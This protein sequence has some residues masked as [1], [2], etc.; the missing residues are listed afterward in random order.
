[1][2][3]RKRGNFKG[4][5]KDID[6]F[7]VAAPTASDTFDK[8]RTRH[9]TYEQ[10]PYIVKPKRDKRRRTEEEEDSSVP[11][12]PY[13][14]T[15]TEAIDTE[16]GQEITQ[17]IKEKAYQRQRALISQRGKTGGPIYDIPRPLSIPVP[18]PE[19]K[20]GQSSQRTTSVQA[21]VSTPQYGEL[22]IKNRSLTQTPKYFDQ[23][24]ETMD[25]VKKLSLPTG[26]S[27]FVNYRQAVLDALD[28]QTPRTRSRAR[29][30]LSEI[31][32]PPMVHGIMPEESSSDQGRT[33]SQPKF[34]VYVPMTQS[35]VEGTDEN[36][37]SQIPMCT[38]VE[39][40]TQF[41]QT[42]QGDSVI[43]VPTMTLVSDK[44]RTSTL[45]KPIEPDFYLPGGVRLSEVKTYR[46]EELS[47]DG[48]PAVMVKLS[49]LKTVYNTDM[50]ML[51]KY[52]GHLF[53]TDE[54]GVYMKTQ[55]KGW[56][57]PTESTMEEPLAGNIPHLGSITPQSIQLNNFKKTP[58]AESTRDQIPTSTPSRTIRE[59]LNQRSEKSPQLKGSRESTPKPKTVAQLLAE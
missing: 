23:T 27:A 9:K 7:L 36:K 29:R 51:D 20:W 21:V 4:K 30:S 46:V 41:T 39:P 1:M 37:V 14:M 47:P 55:E 59:I 24:Q 40:L 31:I 45:L 50:F 38:V 11:V 5:T 48:N 17:F 42:I 10:V 13:Q 32:V 52:L 26:P 33:Q 18:E 57:F 28:Q 53:V 16:E 35:I 12:S 19:D 56:I 43:T 6:L 22:G 15:S 34:E 49:S 2:S 58:E 25:T 54:D 8:L 44:V 3:Q